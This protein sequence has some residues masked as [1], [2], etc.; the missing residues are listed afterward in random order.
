MT[1]GRPTG[2]DEIVAGSPQVPAATGDMAA[3]S[4]AATGDAA[5]AARAAEL[6]MDATRSAT[7]QPRGPESVGEPEALFER[8]DAEL[9]RGRWTDV[10]AAFVDDPRQA[11]QEADQLVADLMQRLAKR[12]ADEKARLEADWSLGGEISTED[13]R[14]ALQHYRA[15]FDR[16]LAL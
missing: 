15:F 11:V 12:F 13:L 6:G 4:M 10:Q 16:L 8:H 14:V 1:D 5:A 2:T 9:F 7:P 3:A